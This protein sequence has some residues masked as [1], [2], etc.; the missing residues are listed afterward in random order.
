MPCDIDCDAATMMPD[1]LP[2]LPY[3]TVEMC[4]VMGGMDTEGE[5]FD[6]MLVMLLDDGGTEAGVNGVGKGDGAEG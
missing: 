5:M 1:S 4:L 3:V 6:D 2:A